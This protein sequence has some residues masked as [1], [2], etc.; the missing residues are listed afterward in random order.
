MPSYLRVVLQG[1]VGE[2]VGCVLLQPHDLAVV[3]GALLL[4]VALPLVPQP[5]GRLRVLFRQWDSL[6]VA[7][8]RTKTVI[9]N[10]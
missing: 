6:L 5:R 2:R 7:K 4:P 10:N 1:D 3:L 8:S 9:I